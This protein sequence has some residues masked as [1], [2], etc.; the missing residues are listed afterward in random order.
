MSSTGRSDRPLAGRRLGTTREAIGDLEI[1]LEQLGAE[2]EHVPLIEIVDHLEVVTA[3]LEARDG[4]A[5]PDWLVVTSR[6]GARIMAGLLAEGGSPAEPTRWQSTRI[7]AVGSATADEF[8]TISSRPVAF[9]PE[10][11]LATALVEHFASE[12][13]AD[14]VV[15]QADRAA[16][17]LVDGLRAGGHRVEVITAY[18]TV[19][20][21]PESGDL[22]RLMECDAVVLM[23]GS[24]A[25]SLRTAAPGH[26][27]PLVV[28]GPSTARAAEECGLE[29]AEVAR[30]HSVDGVAEAVVGYFRRLG[31]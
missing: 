16:P 8:T 2:I 11:Q 27:P 23:S 9:V 10:Q 12:P 20:R 29:V 22:D 28:I 17:T 21:S 4:D 30:E 26:T 3:A 6:P 15:A 5:V 7:A 19:L 24:A 25:V 13:S 31:A 14:I 1:R 18:S